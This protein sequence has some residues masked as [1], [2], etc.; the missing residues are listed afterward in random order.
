MERFGEVPREAFHEGNSVARRVE[1]EAN[2]SRRPLAYGEIQALFDAADARSGKIRATLRQLMAEH[3]M[4]QTSDLVPMLADR[5]IKLS[6]EQVHRLVTQSPAA[7]SAARSGPS[8]PR[9][10]W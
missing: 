4:F 7:R 5:G 2:P 8:P 9:P 10:A 1:F 6:R 3:G